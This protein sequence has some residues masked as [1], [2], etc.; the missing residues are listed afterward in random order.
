MLNQPISRPL[1]EFTL[2]GYGAL[3]EAFL[4]KGYRTRSF[5]S[6]DLSPNAPHLIL[7]HD[8]DMSLALACKMAAVEQQFG[9]SAVY[10]VLV[11]NVN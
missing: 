6:P 10:F 1:R 7:R 8:V 5:L 2:D 3:V 11:A 4:R 9:V